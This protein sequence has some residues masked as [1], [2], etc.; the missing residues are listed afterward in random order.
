MAN[1][2]AA[3]KKHETKKVEEE[4]DKELDQR[5]KLLAEAEEK[6]AKQI[7]DAK[8][9]AMDMIK[10]QQDK[11][12]AQPLC[13][14]PTPPTPPADDKAAAATAGALKDIKSELGMLQDTLG[15]MT[16]QM[17][18]NNSNTKHA[19]KM[20][21]DA[22]DKLRQG[23]DK[24]ECTGPYTE[25]PTDVSCPGCPQPKPAADAVQSGAA[26]G[27]I[28]IQV[29]KKDG[30]S[31]VD[32]AKVREIANESAAKANEGIL[33]QMEADRNQRAMADIEK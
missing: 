27:G 24:Q 12:K 29:P 26:A 6:A 8:K 15:K 3:L 30:G 21:K 23:G 17:K 14:P 19:I 28:T 4:V 1:K 31:G 13:T 20:I 18:T 5:K 32:E 2:K 7:E 33:K 25:R 22:L 10:A 11:I 16:V 9:A